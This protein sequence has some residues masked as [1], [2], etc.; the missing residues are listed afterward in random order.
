M[1]SLD[2]YLTNYDKWAGIQ[3]GLRRTVMLAN[4]LGDRLLGDN[5]TGRHFWINWVTASELC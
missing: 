3:N 5:L 1:I 4:R 2:K